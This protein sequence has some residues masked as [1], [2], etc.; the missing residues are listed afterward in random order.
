[1]GPQGPRGDNGPEAQQNIAIVNDNTGVGAVTM[2]GFVNDSGVYDYRAG[3]SVPDLRNGGST[4]P[5]LLTNFKAGLAVECPYNGYL[6]GFSWWN[7]LVKGEYI[8][9]EGTST[10]TDK[11]TNSSHFN[12]SNQTGLPHS[13]HTECKRFD[14]TFR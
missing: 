7:S 11:I 3:M 13:Y 8:T 14:A 4:N 10:D 5:A 9:S 6:N 2:H 12:K 1:M